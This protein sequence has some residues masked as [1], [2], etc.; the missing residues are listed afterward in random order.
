MH[1][2]KN[3]KSERENTCMLHNKK[4][5]QKTKLKSDDVNQCF[6][7]KLQQNANAWVNI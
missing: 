6:W 1:D 7:F 4:G 2:I 5:M 3:L